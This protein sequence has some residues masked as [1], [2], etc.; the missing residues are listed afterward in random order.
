MDEAENVD[1]NDVVGGIRNIANQLGQTGLG[2]V[3][4]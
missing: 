3:V 4:R 1:E 2:T